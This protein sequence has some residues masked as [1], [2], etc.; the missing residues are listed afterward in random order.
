M[1]FYSKKRGRKIVHTSQCPY[2]IRMNR[3]RMEIFHTVEEAREKGYRLCKDCAPMGKYY[4]AEYHE[5]RN[6]ADENGIIFDYYDGSITIRTPYSQWKIITNGRKK[7]LFL[8]HKNVYRNSFEKSLVP[9]Y[10]SQSVRRKSILAYM[11]YIV[12]HDRYRLRNPSYQ[13]PLIDGGVKQ[14]TKRYK[15]LVVKRKKQERYD[16]IMRVLALIENETEYRQMKV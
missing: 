1:Y 2:C 10:H 4:R 15:K 11:N 14:G 8:Y 6:Y 5:I 12:E 3:E 7:E 16:S 9:G 13:K